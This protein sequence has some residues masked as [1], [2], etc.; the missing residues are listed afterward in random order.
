[1]SLILATTTTGSIAANLFYI[2][3]SALVGYAFEAYRARAKIRKIRRGYLEPFR[4]PTSDRRNSILM[5]GLGGT[6]KTQLIK[7]LLDNEEAEP[8][9]KTQGFDIYF[10]TYNSGKMKL[11]EET[12]SRKQMS[13]KYWLFIADYKGQN[14]GTLVSAFIQQQKR[15]YSPLAY[16]HINS[17]ILVVDLWP[18]KKNKQDPDIQPQATVNDDRVG[19]NLNS[20]NDTAI[21]AVFGLLTREIKYVC[22]FV[23]KV[24]LMS[25]RDSVSNESYIKEYEE[26]KIRMNKRWDGQVDVLLGSAQNG[27]GISTLRRRLM[28]NSVLSEQQV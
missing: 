25:K 28:E 10:S 17:L 20:W 15:E 11:H 9:E 22:I 7:S 2:V 13:N 16:G 12:S 27:M 6:G 23:N 8:K 5:I 1:M 14:L 3:L 18:P 24:D 26:L 21:D 4:I 19:K